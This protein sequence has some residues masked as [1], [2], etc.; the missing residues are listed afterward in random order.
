MSG[1]RDRSR[2]VRD[3]AGGMNARVGTPR[4]LNLQPLLGKIL[5]HIAYRALNRR[6]SGLNLPATEFSSVISQREFY[7]LHRLSMQ[8]SHVRDIRCRRRTIIS[9]VEV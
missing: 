8:L 5:Q 2:R 7:I 6:L 1:A 9:K 3:L 4:A